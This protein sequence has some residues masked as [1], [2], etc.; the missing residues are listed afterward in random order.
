MAPSSAAG[1]AWIDPVEAVPRP[2]EDAVVR[3]LLADRWGIVAELTR[4]P[5]ECD[6]VFLTLEA[7]G[8]RRIL[9]VVS[10][11]KAEANL[12][13]QNAALGAVGRHSPQLPV[14]VVIPS[15]ACRAVEQ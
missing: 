11:A 5:T 12:L 10:G 2:L 7:S 6:Q 14:P 1:D 15:L 8:R 9:R 4:L 3:S 13:L